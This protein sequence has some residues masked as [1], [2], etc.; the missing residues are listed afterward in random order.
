MNIAL[1][2][3]RNVLASCQFPA[4][5]SVAPKDILYL[6]GLSVSQGLMLITPDEIFIFLDGRY[7]KSATVPLPFKIVSA[8][9]LEACVE[10]L[11]RYRRIGFDPKTLTFSLHQRL[12]SLLPATEFF[13]ERKFFQ[14][15]RR[16]KSPDEISAIR[17]A[18]LLCERGYF[19]LLQQIQVG[20]TEKELASNLKCFWF[21][22]GADALSFEP[23]IAFKEHTAC[24]HWH[25]TSTPL[26]KDSI[27][28]I[29]IGVSV[30]GYHSDMTRTFFFGTPDPEL[31]SYYSIVKQAYELAV[32]QARAGT[33]P[34]SLDLAVREFFSSH[35]CAEFCCHSLG[36]GVGL[37]VHESPRINHTAVDEDALMPGD[38]IAIEPGLYLPGKGGIRLEN[39][40]VI[41]EKG[42]ES[43]FSRSFTP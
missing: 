3:A 14:L 15:L 36:H 21:S 19:H 33:L 22:H 2:H 25:P 32:K 11:Q 23:I 41:T 8:Q 28:L 18:C 24:P 30:E 20:V 5:I 43:L 39:T 16:P 35:G 4:I 38:V 37:E 13:P 6:S 10:V 29:D 31:L 1:E 40:I 42:S 9:G 26:E 34:C 17:D 7:A 12:L 27:V